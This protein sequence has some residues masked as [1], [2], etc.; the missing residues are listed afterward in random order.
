VGDSTSPLPTSTDP[1]VEALAERL[2]RVD[3]IAWAQITERAEGLGLSF[4]HLRLLLALATI[5]GAHSVSDLARMSGL[6]LSTAYKA[7]HELRAR[8]YLHEERR[9][10]S[11]TDEGRDLIGILAAAHRE[12]IQAYVDGLD[13]DERQ[14][15]DEVIRTMPT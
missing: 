10:Y 5:E 6:P 4:E 8:G 13:P 9:R 1:V 3:L 15:L 2:R 11:L 12:G 14:R 7:T